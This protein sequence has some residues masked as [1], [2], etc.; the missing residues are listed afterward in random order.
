VNEALS[1]LNWS[2]G[3]TYQAY[4]SLHRFN[5]LQAEVLHRVE[6]LVRYQ[7]PTEPLPRGVEA[8][9]ELL[10]GRGAYGDSS[11]SAVLAPF[12]ADRVS[13]PDGEGGGAFFPDLL[14]A[15]DRS[16]VEGESQLL[17]DEEELQRIKAERGDLR[18]YYDPVLRRGGKK[19][20]RFVRS[21]VKRG[22][23]RYTRTPRCSAG[24]FFVWKKDRQHLRMILDAR[25]A[26]RIFRD[27]PGVQLLTAEDLSAFQVVLPDGVSSESEEGRYLLHLASLTVAIG[28]VDN[29]FH[30]LRMPLWMGEFFALLPVR[31]DQVGMC[32]E[33]FGDA[34]LHADDELY[35]VPCAL[36]MGFAWSLYFCQRGGETV[37]S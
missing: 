32:G 34:V 24:L 23:F 13:L 36:P 3:F 16:L 27:P 28:D 33:K 9:R 20:V 10:A 37:S 7:E 35:P 2:S 30:R 19:Y 25:P 21:L 17:R 15:G 18:P 31:A 22:L 14:D 6:G 4:G 12:R 8:F 29:A 26:N 11:P 1:Y 5:A